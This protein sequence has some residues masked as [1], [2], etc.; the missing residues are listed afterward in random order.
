MA[1]SQPLSYHSGAKFR[2]LDNNCTLVSDEYAAILS[3]QPPAGPLFLLL[4][5][6]KMEQPTA[7]FGEKGGLCHNAQCEPINTVLSQPTKND[8]S[9]RRKSHSRKA[10]WCCLLVLEHPVSC[11][12]HCIEQNLPLR[13]TNNL[14]AMGRCSRKHTAS[15]SFF[16]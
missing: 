13:P 1:L 11:H 6:A 15:S 9:R 3:P 8:K 14:V 4:H 7:A 5:L 12:M 2:Q 10:P 16:T